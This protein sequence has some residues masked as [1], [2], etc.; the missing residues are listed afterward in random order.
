MSSALKED[1]GLLMLGNLRHATEVHVC[2]TERDARALWRVYGH[3]KKGVAVIA[4]PYPDELQYLEIPEK[5]K[6]YA[7]PPNRVTEPMW[8]PGINE[9]N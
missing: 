4:A 6:V 8:G 9:D 1:G 3:K 2:M 5:V 7:W